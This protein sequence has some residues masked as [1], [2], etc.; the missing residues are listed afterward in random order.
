VDFAV[1]LELTLLP[2]AHQGFIDLAVTSPEG[3]FAAGLCYTLRLVNGVGVQVFSPS[4]PI[5]STDYGD[6]TGGDITYTMP[7]D[8]ETAENT[9]TLWLH[10]PEGVVNFDNPCPALDSGTV[11]T[12]ADGCS[13]TVPCTKNED[14]PVSFDFESEAR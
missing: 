12:W 4:G 6:G 2:E 5:C 7:C 11:E 1:T 9:L 3:Q 10:P 13:K 14:T 8:T